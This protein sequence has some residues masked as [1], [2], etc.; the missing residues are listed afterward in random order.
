MSD[1]KARRARDSRGTVARSAK[2]IDGLS[3]ITKTGAVQAFRS[4]KRILGLA[5]CRFKSSRPDNEVPANK[6]FAWAVRTVLVTVASD[7]RQ[8]E[9]PHIPGR[10][11]CLSGSFRWCADPNSV[12]IA[13]RASCCAL[14][15]ASVCRVCAL[16]RRASR[17]ST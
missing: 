2:D 1:R 12:A 10:G 11:R 14:L 13:R 15:P 8:D 3:R 5:L 16:S 9:V 17:G 4:T 7:R 6:A